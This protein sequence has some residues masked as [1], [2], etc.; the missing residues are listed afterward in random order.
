MTI[1]E[2][3]DFEINQLFYR[4]AK[5][6]FRSRFHLSKKDKEYVLEKGVETIQQHAYDFIIKRLAPCHL[7]NDGKQTPMKG[8]P[9]FLAQHAT[10]TCCRGCLFKWHHIS[11]DRYLTKEEIDYVVQV[12][13]RWIK[14]EVRL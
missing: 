13:M 12:I 2:Y 1:S 14:K 7:E 3:Q 5:S 4:L 11:K 9:V 6:R 10:A 8:H